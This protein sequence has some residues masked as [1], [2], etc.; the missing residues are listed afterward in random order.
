MP[1]WYQTINIP[2]VDASFYLSELQDTANHIFGDSL[3]DSLYFSFAGSVDTTTLTEDIFI[4]P[5]VG[6]F[7]VSQGFSEISDVSISLDE[8]ITNKIKLSDILPISF[9]LAFPFTIPSVPQTQILDEEY[10]YGIFEKDGIPFFKRVDYITIKSGSFSTLIKNELYVTLDSVLVQLSNTEGEIIAESFYEHIYHGEEKE[11]NSDLEGKRLMDSLFVVVSASISD[12]SNVIIPANTDPYVDF[13][14]G[15]EIGDIES[16]TGI[17]EPIEMNV[18][19]GIPPSNNTIIRAVIGETTTTPED[20]N[21]IKFDI[22]NGL[23]IDFNID[24][25]F[26]NFY[27]DDG[28]LEIDT[29]IPTGELV[30][31]IKRLDGDTLRNPDAS[32]IV[33]SIMVASVVTLLP[34]TDDTLTT[35]PFDIG[36]GSVY[37]SIEVTCIKMEEIVG[38]FNESFEIPPMS[39]SNIPSGF[40][41]LNFGTVLLKLDFFNEIQAQTELALN[42][43]GFKEDQEP[44][45]IEVADT[46]LKAT[47]SYPVAESEVTIDIAPIFNLMPDSIIVSGEAAIPSNDTSRLQVG[48]SFWGTYSIVVPF[49]VQVNPMTFIPVKST[50]LAPMDSTTQK[51]IRDGLVEASVVTN[52]VNDFPISGVVQILFA[53]YDYV[54]VDSE[55]ASLDTGY[56]WIDDSLFAVSDTDTT[57]I[58]IDTLISLTLPEP[59]ELN[60]DGSVS[61]PGELYQVSTLDSAKL[62]LVLSDEDH[63]IRPRIHLAE[64]DTFVWIG[65]NDAIKILAMISFTMNTVGLLSPEEE[66]EDTTTVDTLS[67]ISMTKPR[68]TE[69]HLIIEEISASDLLLSSEKERKRFNKKM[70]ER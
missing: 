1:T 44:V 59:V 50:E 66:P 47:D 56:Q 39:I 3:S 11:N 49:V 19:Q 16:I 63:F 8:T 32:S 5:A 34:N 38:F 13:S 53:N 68:D 48:K 40:S 15:I 42:L 21:A 51:R 7:E 22:N 10:A 18:S 24:I 31:E 60:P 69:N 29:D 6:G 4:V 52:V 35:I 45:L 12:T 26:L 55:V 9:P 65:Y 14:V 33:D 17:P 57:Y 54:P 23:P 36:D 58:D 43:Q 62:G 28:A 67:K 20:T 61:V 41:D 27:G 2:V 30:S 70:L 25:K 37:M 64:T 46:I